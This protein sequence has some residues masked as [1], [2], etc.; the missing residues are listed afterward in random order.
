M[1]ML[2]PNHGEVL[3]GLPLLLSETF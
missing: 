2:L 1:G 3:G